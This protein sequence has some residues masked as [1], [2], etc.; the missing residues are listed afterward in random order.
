[1]S[2]KIALKRVGVV[3]GDVL[4]EEGEWE[5]NATRLETESRTE[6]KFPN[7][8]KLEREC[9]GTYNQDVASDQPKSN[10]ER[11][12]NQT[13][14]PQNSLKSSISCYNEL[15]RNFVSNCDFYLSSG[16][17]SGSEK[18][19]PENSHKTIQPKIQE[20]KNEKLQP[21]TSSSRLKSKKI[22]TGSPQYFGSPIYIAN[23]YSYSTDV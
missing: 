3:N 13:R 8:T 11:N 12:R 23:K 5:N 14:T 17:R 19:C 15:N 10:Q 22:N 16:S 6:P 2:V 1:M 18:Y 7:P 9:R 20:M 4:I 21:T